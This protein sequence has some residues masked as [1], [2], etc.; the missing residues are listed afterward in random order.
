MTMEP[1]KELKLLLREEQSPFFN[2]AELQYHLEQ[3]GG[4][5]R[6]AAYNCCLLKAEDDSINLPGGLSLP[7]NRAYWMGLARRYR[8]NQSKIL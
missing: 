3:A 7:S 8:T 4:D 6:L 1:I 2:D 5:V